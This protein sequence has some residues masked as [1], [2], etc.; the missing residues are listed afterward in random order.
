MRCAQALPAFLRAAASSFRAVGQDFGLKSLP[1][2]LTGDA[3]Q[4]IQLRLQKYDCQRDP[5]DEHKLYL[6]SPKCLKPDLLI[7]KIQLKCLAYFE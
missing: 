4:Q 7:P 1:C 5:S 3:G 6:S 2:I